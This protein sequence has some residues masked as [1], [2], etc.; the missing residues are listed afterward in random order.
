[1]VSKGSSAPKTAALSAARFV[2]VVAKLL[3]FTACAMAH[4]GP[5]VWGVPGHSEKWTPSGVLASGSSAPNGLVI[6]RDATTSGHLRGHYTDADGQV[7][8][9]ETKR[10]RRYWERR[11]KFPFRRLR[12]EVDVCIKDANGTP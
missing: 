5:Q 3:A 4:E 11:R 2:I 10:G 12:H 1:M 8:T 7:V 9:F 6:E